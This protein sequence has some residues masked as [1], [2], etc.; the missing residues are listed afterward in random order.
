MTTTG[1]APILIL[2]GT[3]EATELARELTA[4]GHQVVVSFAGRTNPQNLPSGPKRVGGF[5]G[6][7]GLMNELR[8]GGYRL[9]IDATHPFAT[10]SLIHI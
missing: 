4:R 5:D 8:Q 10:L 2:G 3:S 1:P 7:Q 9:L 6:V